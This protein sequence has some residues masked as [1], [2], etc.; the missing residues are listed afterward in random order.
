MFGSGAS[1]SPPANDGVL[2][3]LPAQN[4]SWARSLPSVPPGVNLTVTVGHP[5]L[6]PVDEHQLAEAGYR[7][8]GVASDHRPI[9]KIV[10]V[11]L[12]DALLHDHPQWCIELRNRAERVFNLRLGPVQRVLAAELAMHQRALVS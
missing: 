3:R 1:A 4:R 7:I 5:K 8:V 10:D 12:P 6:L 9:G 2:V 11:L